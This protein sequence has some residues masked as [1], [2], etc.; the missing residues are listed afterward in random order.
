MISACSARIIS[1]FSG[2]RLLTIL[3][4]EI[5]G[6]ECV[7]WAKK[8]L[9]NPDFLVFKEH[10]EPITN[11]LDDRIDFAEQLIKCNILNSVILSITS[12][13]EFY[14]HDIVT[15]CLRRN[16]SLRKQA[17]ANYTIS[18]KE[19]EEFISLNEIKRKHFDIIATSQTSG[20]LFSEKIKKTKTFL[21]LKNHP[22]D[23]QLLKSLESIW[24]L[25]N[26]LA[27][28]NHNFIKEFSFWHKNSEIKLS[29]D[30]SRAEYQNFITSLCLVLEDLL[31]WIVSFDK[32]ARE[33]WPANDFIENE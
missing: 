28:S 22:L 1:N 21:G 25:R 7:S 4:N 31:A 32:V 13:V 3:S 11:T 16:S 15:L 27:H 29:K 6:E 26:K 23:N 19:L 18:G 20:S 9:G 14:L 2:I 8:S 12:S 33:K 17:F 5:T 30:Y 10:L 24:E